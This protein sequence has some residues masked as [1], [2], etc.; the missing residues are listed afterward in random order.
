MS[1][2]SILFMIFFFT[3]ETAIAQ[4]KIY[5]Q[6]DSLIAVPNYDEALAQIS[7]AISTTPTVDVEIIQNKKAEVLIL[8]GKLDEA[9]LL[10][11]QIKS[12]NNLFRDGITATNKGFLA[13]NKARNDVALENLKYALRVFE[14]AGKSNSKEAALC[15]SHLS[16]VYLSIG[17]L[18]QALENGLFA[19]QIRQQL[20]G[21]QSEVVAASYN[22]LGVVYSQIDA[23]KALD[24]YDKAL[25]IYEKLHTKK[26]PKIAIA[27]IN[28]GII[29]QQLKLYGDAVNS[30]ETAEKIW[31][32]IYPNGHPNQALALFNLGKTYNQMGDNTTAIAFF[33]KSIN[34]Y[35]RTLGEKH[36]SL[37]S[38]YNQ[39]G[40]IYLDRNEY[41]K[42]LNCAQTALCSNILSF[43]KMDI[44][45]NPSMN[46]FYNGK[47]FLYSLQLKAE[48]LEA[49]HFGKSLKFSDLKLALS[50]LFKADSL[51][52]IIRH[53][54]DDENDKIALGA[55]ASDTYENAVS[56]AIAMSEMTVEAKRYREIAFHFAEKSKSAVLQES[57]ADS[58]AKSFAGIP[59]TL[60]ENEVVLKSSLALINQKL[61]QKPT[62]EEERILR[63][64][65]FTLNQQ[66]E[67]FTRNLENDYPEY[68][69]LKYENKNPTIKEI[70]N[71]L[72]NQTA[73]VSY[74]IAEKRKKIFRFMV[75]SNSYKIIVTSIP[76]NFHRIVSGFGNSLL[77]NEATFY[78]A[79]APALSKVLLAEIP[80]K[81]SNLVIIPTGKLSALPFEALLYK[82]SLNTNFEQNPFL[83]KKYAISYE[84]SAGLFIQK[85]KSSETWKTPT[86]FLCAPIQ[87]NYDRGLDDLPGTEQEVNAIASL[88]KKE[89]VSLATYDEASEERVKNKQMK[90]YT[91]IHF[92]TH[93]IVDE[94]SPELSRIFLGTGKN[95]DGNLFS[96]EIYNLS[97]PAELA[98]LSAC[99]TGLGKVS[100]GE[101]VIGLSRA[102][103]YSGVRNMVV[104]FW[105]VNDQSTTQLMTDFYKNLLSKPS[106]HFKSAL[107]EAKL[108]MINNK[109]YASPFYWAPFVLIGQ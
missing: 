50:C 47:V 92:A 26:H 57:I 53:S 11:S 41:D 60:L 54:S 52:D 38:V 31:N 94:V 63:Q 22:D 86:V 104:S 87:F 17:K 4:E 85:S 89:E 15:L 34:L 61:S 95:E 16:F 7:K 36:P 21:E 78:Q 80:R 74:F 105:R 79:T 106:D 98:V 62:Q 102:L 68:F 76:D 65:L 99:Q 93:G 58:E 9:E 39:L 97:L 77:F 84:F 101:G 27:N 12:G 5:A 20:Y 28:L 10:L 8:T 66:Y 90:T 19:L 44:Q 81:V 73:L 67:T 2:K 46:D 45:L 107:R 13:L 91:Y 33:D 71:K 64:Q 42:A 29:Y 108:A 35:K 83:I 18:N 23:D 88:F 55:I 103:T 6:I 3:I 82:N 40:L 56:L 30:F 59:E 70:Q 100:K 14:Q 25:V 49:R 43:D 37:S 32:S 75:T 109:T 51:L 24:F 48:A 72:D 1:K 96:G 69:K